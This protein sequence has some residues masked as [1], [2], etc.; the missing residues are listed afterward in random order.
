MSSVAAKAACDKTTPDALLPELA[1]QAV[2]GPLPVEDDDESV[3]LLVL[4]QC[5]GRGLLRHAAQQ[6]GHDV[7]AHRER[8]AVGA[9]IRCANIRKDKAARARRAGAGGHEGVRP[10]R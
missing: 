9:G 6:F 10:H 1:Q 2:R 8:E 5:G 7:V 3:Q 4:T